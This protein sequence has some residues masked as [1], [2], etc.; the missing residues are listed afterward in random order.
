MPGTRETRRPAARGSWLC[1]A[2]ITLLGAGGLLAQ[3]PRIGRPASEEKINAINLTV[4]PDGRGLPEGKGTVAAG[5]DLF[6]EKC[7]VCHNDHGEGRE[8][9]RAHV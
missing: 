1:L 7:A 9:G 5:K 8:I 6:K 2:A 3:K 4:M